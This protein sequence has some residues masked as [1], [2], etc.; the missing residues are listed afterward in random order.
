MKKNGVE[1]NSSIILIRVV[2]QMAKKK[3]GL[4]DFNGD[5]KVDL[6]EILVS[7]MGMSLLIQRITRQRKNTKKR[8][9]RRETSGAMIRKTRK[10]LKKNNNK[11][12]SLWNFGF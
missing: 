2:S 11:R 4:F 10:I 8:W 3:G 5:G 1:Y 12:G 9:K 6:G 7:M